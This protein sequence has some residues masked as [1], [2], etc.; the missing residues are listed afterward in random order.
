MIGVINHHDA[1]RQR[2]EQ[3]LVEAPQ[4]PKIKR[5]PWLLLCVWSLFYGTSRTTASAPRVTRSWQCRSHTR[6]EFRSHDLARAAIEVPAGSNRLIGRSRRMD[7]F[8]PIQEQV[9]TR[10]ER[11]GPAIQHQLLDIGGEGTEHV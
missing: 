5:W 11:E 6:K 9:A 10:K 3:Q 8:C 2:T 7:A 4:V 1:N